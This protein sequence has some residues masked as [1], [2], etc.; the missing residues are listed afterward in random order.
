MPLFCIGLSLTHSAS[1]Q[2]RTR[3]ILTFWQR[4]TN[5][6]NCTCSRCALFSPAEQWTRTRTVG[7]V[8]SRRAG[9]QAAA[10]PALWGRNTNSTATFGAGQRHQG[11]RRLLLRACH[12]VRGVPVRVRVIGSCSGDMA[13]PVPV[14]ASSGLQ[15]SITQA[16]RPRPRVWVWRTPHG[17]GRMKTWEV[18]KIEKFHIYFKKNSVSWFC[19]KRAHWWPWRIR[20]VVVCSRWEGGGGTDYWAWAM[21]Y[22]VA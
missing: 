6:K 13:V 5:T 4:H 3:S 16:A 1:Q 2:P 8:A 14:R 18:V 9:L 15:Y 20:V 22:V 12:T 7:L 11:A 21:L 19:R 17:R 10:H